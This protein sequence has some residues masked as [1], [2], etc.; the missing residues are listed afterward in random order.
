MNFL[1]D[2]YGVF[3]IKFTPMGLDD[4]KNSLLKF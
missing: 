1:N 4:G 3:E 2:E